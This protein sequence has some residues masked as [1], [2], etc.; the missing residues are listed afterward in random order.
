MKISEHGLTFIKNEEG[1]VL[2]I[3]K[4]VAGFPTIG[5]GHLLTADEKHYGIFNNGIT[6]QQALNILKS[7]VIRFENVLNA[8]VKTQLNQNQFDA[9]LSLIFNCGPFPITRGTLGILLNN[10]E[11]DKVPDEMLKW[12]HSGKNVLPI[13]RDRRVR[14]VNLFLMQV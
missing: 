4:D 5:I 14:E 1:C 8:Y 12:C 13:L 2:H 11:F 6:D 7:D 3:Y 9:L 10:N